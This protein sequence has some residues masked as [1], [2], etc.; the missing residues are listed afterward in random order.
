[1]RSALDGTLPQTAQSLE[2]DPYASL[3]HPC[4]D[5]RISGGP[6]RLTLISS[7]GAGLADQLADRVD[8]HLATF[9]EHMREGLLAASTV[10]GLEVMAKLM[11]TEVTELVGPK[12][13]HG[14]AAT[15]A[16]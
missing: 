6:D 16:P 7:A 10:I 4:P 3:A 14:T 1:V 2:E 5:E 8:G 11:T 13:R 12:S 9:V 15:T